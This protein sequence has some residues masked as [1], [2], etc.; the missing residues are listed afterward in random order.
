LIVVEFQIVV[1]PLVEK[2][3]KKLFFQKSCA[4]PSFIFWKDFSTN[5]PES[6]V[7]LA[8]LEDVEERF[9]SNSEL[10]IKS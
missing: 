3:H 2:L 8:S 7:V 6:R 1:V 5:G 4:S 9:I 10:E